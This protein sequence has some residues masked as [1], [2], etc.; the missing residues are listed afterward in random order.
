MRVSPEHRAFTLLEILVSVAILGM[1]IIPISSL[2]SQG[3]S[4]LREM[5][6]RTIIINI[7]EQ[8][9]HRYI[10]DLSQLES[11]DSPIN[12]TDRDITDDIVDEYSDRLQY[13][14]N[15]K[16]EATVQPA[17]LCV[18]GGSEIII[19]SSWKSGKR[20]VEFSLFNIKAREDML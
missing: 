2:F 7:A 1:A 13:I 12:F 19:K 5:R 11:G 17:S 16:I 4:M 18:S 10:Q 8:Q 3:L 9:I 15:L 6:D 14:R 20:T